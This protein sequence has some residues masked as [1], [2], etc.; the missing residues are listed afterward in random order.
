M[1]LLAWPGAPVDRREGVISLLENRRASYADEKF[2]NMPSISLI[3]T[4]QVRLSRLLFG[5]MNW[6]FHLLHD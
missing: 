4:A 2:A 6:R 3:A 1:T 5:T